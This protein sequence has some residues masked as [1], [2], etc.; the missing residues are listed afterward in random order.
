MD[1]IE[2]ETCW[3][4]CGAEIK[5]KSML[6]TGFFVQQTNLCID[7]GLPPGL[8][9]LLERDH[10]EDVPVQCRAGQCRPGSC[11]HPPP[12]VGARVLAA[13]VE[14]LVP[15]AVGEVEGVAPQHEH[16]HQ[17]QHVL[18]GQP[19]L[20]GHICIILLLKSSLWNC[21]QTTKEIPWCS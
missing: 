13:R 18:R 10:V 9:P 16:E 19:R 14:E 4:P 20:Q 1:F 5:S 2:L 12:H 15:G 21:F 11:R 6:P 17:D 7:Q 8:I 3:Y